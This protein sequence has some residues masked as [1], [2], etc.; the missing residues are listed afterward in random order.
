MEDRELVALAI[1][2]VAMLVSGV[3]ATR[4]LAERRRFKVRQ[5]G[6]GKGDTDPVIE[7]AE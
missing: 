6:R 5:A 4:K 3:L 1:I 7:P 2:V